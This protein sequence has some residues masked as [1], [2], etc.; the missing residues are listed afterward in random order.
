M[1]LCFIAWEIKEKLKKKKK[2]KKDLGVKLS[3]ITFKYLV[4]SV[5]RIGFL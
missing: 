4:T 2:K 5:E 1:Y 3:T